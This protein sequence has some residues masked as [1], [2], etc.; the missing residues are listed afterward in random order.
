MSGG[1]VLA[2]LQSHEATYG[3]IKTLVLT[4]FDEENLIHEALSRG[5][6]GYLLKNSKPDKIIRALES[7]AAGNGVFE[8]SLIQKL[9]RPSEVWAR[10][11]MAQYEL[12]KRELEI[13]QLIARG[14]SNKEIASALYISE[15]T[16]KNYITAILTKMDLKHRTQIAIAYLKSTEK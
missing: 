4:T 13:T 1:E 3:H 15:G 12:S 16:V 14:L 7:V 10:M 8:T 11:Q 9:G 6:C 2:Y 5:A